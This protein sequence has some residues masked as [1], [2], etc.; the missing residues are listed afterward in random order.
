MAGIKFKINP[1]FWLFLAISLYLKRGFFALTY[2]L[3]VVLHECSHY[4]VARRLFYR[5]R[6]IQISIFGA[7]LYGDFDSVTA[8]DR[9]KIALA[10]PLANLVLCVVCLAIWWIF[11][12][13][14]PI[15]NDFFQANISMACVNLLPFYPLDGGRVVT[16]VLQRKRHVDCTHAVKKVTVMFSLLLFALFVVSLFTRHNLFNLG[17]FSLFLFSGAFSKPNG[18]TYVKCAYVFEKTHFLRCGM[19]KKTLVFNQNNTLSDVAKR[20]V[21]NYLYALEVVNDD[22]Q[23]V[24]TFSVYALE[25]LITTHP[26]T[27]KLKD[28]KKITIC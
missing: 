25:K 21:G 24:A 28:V 12:E 4:V 19:E 9:I 11:P 26:L 15:I 8:T 22:M 20:V 17:L 6:E 1:S 7:V 10:G 5:C 3:A 14:Y 27:T 23:V 2:T 13:S 18:E 16:G